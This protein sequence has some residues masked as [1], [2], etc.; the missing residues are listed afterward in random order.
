[1]AELSKKVALEKKIKS[2]K[3]YIKDHII[4]NSKYCHK[5]LIVVIGVR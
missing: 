4:A 5:S 1:M 3:T 2:N